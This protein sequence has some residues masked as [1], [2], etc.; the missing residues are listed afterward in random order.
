VE[1]TLY[2]VANLLIADDLEAWYRSISRVFE[3]HELREFLNNGDEPPV[4]ADVL[5]HDPVR[6]QD[7]T[8]H[9][10][11]LAVWDLLRLAD[12]IMVKVDRV[13]ASTG[14]EARFPLLDHRLV[15]FAFRLPLS[16]TIRAGR[17]KCILL[18][19]LYRYIPE[20]LVERP[21]TGFE[22]PLSEWLCGPL[23]HWVEDLLNESRHRQQGFF[24]TRTVRS[25]W[26]EHLSRQRD[27]YIQLR[28]VLV[29]N[30]CLNAQRD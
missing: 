21:K 20:V 19:L 2:K 9:L 3:K 5:G 23:R 25:K 17:G 1:N 24:N 14:I 6:S 30:E 7:P 18:H 15:E 10:M 4:L 28:S 16:M 26:K 22:V 11:S 29:L 8:R 13:S 27:W 12:T